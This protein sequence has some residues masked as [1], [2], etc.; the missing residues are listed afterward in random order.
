[1]NH[2]AMPSLA[3]VD[4]SQTPFVAIWETTRA[5]DLACRHCRAEAIPEALPGEL[6]TR[7]GFQVLDELSRMGTP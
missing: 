7:E 3:A 5:C 4:F 6:S 2:G 1:M